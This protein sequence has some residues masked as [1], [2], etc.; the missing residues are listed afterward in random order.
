MSLIKIKELPFPVTFHSLKSMW[1]LESNLY[2]CLCTHTLNSKLLNYEPFTA[3]MYIFIQSNDMWL[4]QRRRKHKTKYRT[5]LFWQMPKY[6]LQKPS[7]EGAINYTTVRSNILV[8]NFVIKIV[9]C[10]YNINKYTLHILLQA[11]LHSVKY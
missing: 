1:L 3:L 4:Q 10:F 9:R 2:T 5:W 7:F 8:S 11:V 6:H